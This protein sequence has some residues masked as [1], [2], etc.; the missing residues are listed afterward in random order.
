[1][2]VLFGDVRYALRLLRK[3]PGCT[4]VA[5]ATL[6]LGVGANTA[7][8]STVDAVLIRALPYADPDRVVMVWEDAHEAGF[9]GIARRLTEARPEGRVLRQEIVGEISGRPVS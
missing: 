5:V 2:D 4:A 6:A 1:M 8:F 7:I 9:R 3:S